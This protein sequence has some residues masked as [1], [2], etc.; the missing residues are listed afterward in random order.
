MRWLANQENV[1]GPDSEYIYGR[2]RDRSATIEGTPVDEALYGDIHQY[3]A[4]MMQLSGITPNELPDN[5]YN[6]F[7]IFEAYKIAMY[8]SWQT[9]SYSGTF[10]DD[11][12]SPIR[13]RRK[14]KTIRI[15]GTT[16]NSVLASIVGDTPIFTLPVGYRPLETQ[17]FTTLETTSPGVAYIQVTSAGVVSIRADLRNHPN[18]TVWVNLSFDID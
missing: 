12:S 3:I 15:K 2:I 8:E 16:D 17:I 4:R 18:T 1:D 13:Y 5:D 14:G 7:Q 11:G 6:G 9:P 10:Q